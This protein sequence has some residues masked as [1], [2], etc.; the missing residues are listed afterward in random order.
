M[1]DAVLVGSGAWIQARSMATQFIESDRTEDIDMLW[2]RHCPDQEEVLQSPVM[3]AF[4]Q[5]LGGGGCRGVPTTVLVQPILTVFVVSDPIPLEMLP[6]SDPH[7][8]SR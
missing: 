2:R 8:R 5:L 1:D 3:P 4:N 6:L 7:H